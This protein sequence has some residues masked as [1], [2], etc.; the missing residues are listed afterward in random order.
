[1]TKM[2]SAVSDLMLALPWLMIKPLEGDNDGLVSVD[3]AV[4]GTFRG[5][6]ES[7]GRRGISHGDI[8]DLK[9]ADYRGFDVVETYVAIV[10]DLKEKGF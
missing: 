2:K 4:W 6:L 3:S 1:M 10:A 7:R 5:V 8:I 9:R